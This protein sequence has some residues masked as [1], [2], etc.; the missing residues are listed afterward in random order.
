MSGSNDRSDDGSKPI[1]PSTPEQTAP[2]GLIAR[3][4]GRRRFVI[5]GLAGPAVATLGVQLAHAAPGQTQSQTQ[6]PK[7]KS[8]TASKLASI[9]HRG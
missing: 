1:A 5:A 2:E 7:K 3:R 8:T 9:R 6:A 4:L